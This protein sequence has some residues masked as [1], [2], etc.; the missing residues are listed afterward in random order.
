MQQDIDSKHLNDVFLEPALSFL[1][2]AK[3]ARSC[4]E[5]SDQLWLEMGVSR[6]LA[7]VRSGRDFLQEWAM[8][9]NHEDVVGVSSFFETLKSERRCS[10]V[11]EINTSLA[12]SLATHPDL[13]ADWQVVSELKKVEVFAGD[14]HYHAASTHDAPI[15]G[16]RRAVG[17]F[18][19]LNL[20][21]HALTH[22]EH[23]DLESLNK[24]ND[25]DMAMLKRLS[26]EQLRQGV[27]MGHRGKRVMYVWD[28]AGIDLTQW[29][30][31]KA[32]AGIYFVSLC[33]ENFDIEVSGE[34][35]FDRLD[36]LNIGVIA[37][38]LVS[39]QS[40]G[41]LFRRVRYCCPQSGKHFEFITNYMNM[42]PGVIA[43][44]YKRRWDIEKTY[45]TFKNKLMEKK[46]WAKSAVAKRMQA[47]FLCL[48]HNLI[49]RLEKYLREHHGIVNRRESLRSLGRLEAELKTPNKARSPLYWN[50]FKRSQ[51][52]LK[53]IR[54]L[55]HH[56]RYDEPLKE[57]I[58]SLRVVYES[59]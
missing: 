32:K 55:R 38:E 34:R 20:R 14:G 26:I 41:K 57:A 30:A 22:L 45:D 37:D 54:W 56:I 6:V 27:P 31:W 17:H 58:A 12:Q 51:L 44:L 47:Q 29:E 59:F 23:S 39:T 28:K 10:L 35:D 42:R 33:K 24:K 5:L 16:K 9:N 36:A 8:A 15:E 4:P 19:A 13:E 40:F 43:W 1:K 3:H 48:C 21:T 46:A 49:V 50:R 7:D 25:H 11:T 52:C 2:D 18:Y 53:F